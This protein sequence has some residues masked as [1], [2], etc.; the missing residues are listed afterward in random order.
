[1]LFLQK[2]SNNTKL[3]SLTVFKE[4]KEIPADEAKVADTA[5][6]GD[7]TILED[8]KKENIIKNEYNIANDNIIDITIDRNYNRKEELNKKKPHY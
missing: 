8:N 3:A 1:M 6:A 5:L 7:T 4:L 2:V